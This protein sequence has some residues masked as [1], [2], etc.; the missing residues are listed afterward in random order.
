MK[1][2]EM[3]NL[4]LNSTRFNVADYFSE[5][6][7]V[8]VADI[9]VVNADIIIGDKVECTMDVILFGEDVCPVYP[10]EA[11]AL[12]IA[13]AMAVIAHNGLLY[14]MTGEAQTETL[15]HF[16]DAYNG[17][18]QIYDEFEAEVLNNDKSR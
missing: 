8:E 6:D 13:K 10:N 14:A 17:M 18:G 1:E 4:K 9:R 11:G 5:K 7:N 2:N 3:V 16:N 15:K 12:N